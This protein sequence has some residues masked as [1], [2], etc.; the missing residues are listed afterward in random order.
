MTTEEAVSWGWKG[1]AAVNFAKWRTLVD[2]E[3]V[4]ASGLSSM[5]MGDWDY[6][7]AFEE[8]ILPVHAAHE[9]LASNGFPFGEE[10]DEPDMVWP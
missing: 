2:G 8:G 4:K 3:M 6:A 7:S 10:D 9:A 1:E 5:D